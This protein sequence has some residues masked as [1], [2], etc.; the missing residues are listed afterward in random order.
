MNLVKQPLI[1]IAPYQIVRLMKT[2]LYP[3]SIHVDL[4]LAKLVEKF[5]LYFSE[6]K[7]INFFIQIKKSDNKWQHIGELVLVEDGI[8]TASVDIICEAN[9]E[10]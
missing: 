10:S 1:I 3:I 7:K 6:R 4:R 9:E 2:M 5:F 8:M